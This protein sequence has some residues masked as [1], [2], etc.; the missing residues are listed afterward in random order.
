MVLNIIPSQE[1]NKEYSILLHAMS[2]K[3]LR[4]RLKRQTD[5]DPG[6]KDFISMVDDPAYIKMYNEVKAMARDVPSGMAIPENMKGEAKQLQEYVSVRYPEGWK[7]I[8][9]YEHATRSEASTEE[10]VTAFLNGLSTIGLTIIPIIYIPGPNA[11]AVV[12]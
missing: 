5:L 2:D 10:M 11:V 8:K 3:N 7:L 4:D 6:F 1:M 12:A 9:E